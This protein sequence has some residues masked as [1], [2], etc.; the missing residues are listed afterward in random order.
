MIFT[1]K[2]SDILRQFYC[3]PTDKES[4]KASFVP[5]GNKVEIIVHRRAF[6]C[7]CDTWGISS[8]HPHFPSEIVAQDCLQCS[9][10]CKAVRKISFAATRMWA[11]NCKCPIYDTPERLTFGILDQVDLNKDKA[12]VIIVVKKMEIVGRKVQPLRVAEIPKL[13]YSASF[14]TKKP[15]CAS[16]WGK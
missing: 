16:S 1:W 9:F 12:M 6:L 11:C 2:S 5:Q 13:H 4:C 14:F 8:I 15:R 10:Y 3:K 7:L